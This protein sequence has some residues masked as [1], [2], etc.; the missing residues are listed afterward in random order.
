MPVMGDPREPPRSHESE[1]RDIELAPA[2]FQRKLQA[3]RAYPEL[4][5]PAFRREIEAAIRNFGQQAFAREYLFAAA[6]QDRW[7]LPFEKEKPFYETYGERQNLGGP[8]QSVNH[9]REHLLPLS[10]GLSMSSP[11]L[12]RVVQ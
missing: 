7:E 8:S 12:S 5:G 11:A 9:L 2:V 10:K 4:G 3:M 6:P 1:V